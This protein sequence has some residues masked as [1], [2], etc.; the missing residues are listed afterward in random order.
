M[1]KRILCMRVAGAPCIAKPASGAV[2]IGSDQDI[3][4]QAITCCCF[5][6]RL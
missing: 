3:L 2:C 6:S 1:S 4:L 5:S